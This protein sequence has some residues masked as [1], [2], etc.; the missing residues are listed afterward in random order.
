MGRDRGGKRPEGRDK[1]PFTLAQL[2]ADAEG[3]R[4]VL[5]GLLMSLA[6]TLGWWGV[7][8]W[9]PGYVGGI[10]KQAGQDAAYWG[11]VAGI[12]YNVG[13][14]IGYLASGFLRRR[15]GAPTLPRLPL[16]GGL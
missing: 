16:C 13:A 6:T 12:V 15:H 7:A 10:A 3:R 1:R 8:T 9:I 2:F 4:R 5:L 11:S 14:I